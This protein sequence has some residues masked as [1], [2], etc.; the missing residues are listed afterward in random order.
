M[1]SWLRY[2][3]KSLWHRRHL[4]RHGDARKVR[5]KKSQSKSHKKSRRKWKAIKNLMIALRRISDRKN[6]FQRMSIRATTR[7]RMTSIHA[8]LRSV[9]QSPRNLCLKSRS[10]PSFFVFPEVVMLN[11][12]STMRKCCRSTGGR[13]RAYPRM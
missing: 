4:E 12:F 5:G 10:R 11:S 8:K 7:T 2:S 1:K 6:F 9:L 3:L 13:W